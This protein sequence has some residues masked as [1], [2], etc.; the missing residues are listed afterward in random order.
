M[1]NLQSRWLKFPVLTTR[2]AIL[3]IHNADHLRLVLRQSFEYEARRHATTPTVTSVV[4][5]T[6]QHNRGY[7]S[8]AGEDSIFGT[9]HLVD[10]YIITYVSSTAR[11]WS[12]TKQL[13]CFSRP[14]IAPSHCML[15]FSRP[16]IA[17]SHYMLCFSRPL[18][19]PSHYMLCFSRPLIAPSH[20]ILCFSRPLTAPSHYM[21]CF[22]R[23]LTD[24]TI[25]LH[26]L[27]QQAT[28]SPEES[29][30]KTSME[31]V[32]LETEYSKM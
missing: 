9:W 1:K 13:L 32:G 7:H 27:F 18:I 5:V 29:F 6:A 25:S 24:C 28:A 21:L 10:W 2:I 30:L 26:D 4:T 8:G 20:C 3:T 16:L 22:S 12:L 15:C 11:F 23:P 31:N 17:P 19:A 14:L